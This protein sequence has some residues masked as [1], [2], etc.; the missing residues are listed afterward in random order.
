MRRRAFAR[1]AAALAAIG[2]PVSTLLAAD[3]RPAPLKKLGSPQ[4]FDYAVLKGRARALAGRAYQAPAGTLPAEVKALD[5]DQHQSISYRADHALWAD[6]RGRFRAK[7]F[8]LGMFANVPV[9]MHELADGLAQELA[10]DPEMFDYGKSGLQAPRMPRDLGFAGFRINFHS[11]WKHDVAAFQGA[12][13]FRAVGGERQYGLSAR[14][15]AIDSGGNEEFPNFTE[16]WLQRPALDASTLTVYALMDSPSVAGAYRF[17]IL[18]AERLVIDVD[19]ALYPR[20]DLERAGIAALTSMFQCGEN[21]RRMANDWRPEIHDSDGLAMWSGGGEWLW[22]PLV[23]PQHIRFSAFGDDNPRGFGLLQR[24]REFSHY[25]DDGAFYDRRPSLWVEPKSNWGKGSV[26]LVELP[27][28]DETN[29]NIV[30]F[31][32]PEAKPRAGEERLFS[33]RLHWG[34]RP[35]VQPPAARVAATRTGIGGIVGQKRK[36]ASWRFTIDFE[37]G[38][39]SLVGDE[40]QMV[41]MITPSRGIVELTSARPLKSIQGYRAMFDLRLPDDRPT[42]VELRLYLAYRGQPMTETWCYQ[43][44]PPP[45]ARSA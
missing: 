20:K 35:P 11:D 40:S 7:F 4:P 1:S 5:Y 14:G 43:W 42:P 22:R 18:P 19:A 3:G 25:Q 12:S 15:L 13:Y 39:L 26:Q 9:R 29:D 10:Y 33:Y 32:T 37:G 41:P 28:D 30:A 38:D 17:D 45:A 24:D 8:H 34:A 16:F 36:Y 6:G 2:L 44:T 27:T 31:W 21:D 23:N